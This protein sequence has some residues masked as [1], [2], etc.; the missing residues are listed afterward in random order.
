[1]DM[2]CIVFVRGKK[3]DDAML[4]LAVERGIV[5]LSSPLRMYIACGRLYSAGLAGMSEE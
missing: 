1:M 2:K 5:L 3:P 4:N